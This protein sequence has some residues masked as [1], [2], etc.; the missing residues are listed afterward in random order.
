VE[1]GEMESLS[2]SKVWT[3]GKWLR[4][5]KREGERERVRDGNQK[6]ER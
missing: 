4:M 1:E 2:E 5:R 6:W 3:A